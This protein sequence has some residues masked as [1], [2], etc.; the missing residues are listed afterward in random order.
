MS[1]H[2]ENHQKSLIDLETPAQI[3]QRIRSLPKIDLHRHLTGSIDA[4]LAIDIATKYDIF[5]P[6]YIYS[7][8][9][10]I[11]TKRPAA[12][13]H[14]DYFHRWEIL[15]KLFV[16]AESTFDILMNVIKKASED[17][18]VYMELRMGP[19]GFLGRNQFTF[20]DFLKTVARAVH[21]GQ[22]K[23]G[24][25]TRCI[26]GISRHETFSNIVNDV[27]EKMF[28]KI[29]SLI[30]EYYP[31]CFV[32]VDLNGIES[33]SENEL[34]INFFK[35]AKKKGLKI[36]A[37]AGELGSSSNIAKSIEIL[38]ADRIGH[39]LA[40]AKKPEIME[41]LSK[42]DIALEICPKSNEFLGVISNYKEL[43][44]TIFKENNV[45]YVISTDN[46]AICQTTISEELYRIYYSH[47]MSLQEIEAITKK[48]IKYSFATEEVK[49]KIFDKIENWGE[50]EFR[51]EEK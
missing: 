4:S 15:N 41:L 44:L 39:G 22:E 8:L 33:E 40:A 27:R 5:L 43:P 7:E 25:I 11:L 18:I 21:E 6:T 19:R 32:G 42:L 13:S 9:N 30:L 35:I 45:S 26:L 12:L 24:T 51:S 3:M 48:A 31:Y 1:T 16:S 36:T 50:H 2:L 29:I 23:Y 49:A 14:E 10:S 28:Y 46:P 17:N 38:N 47:K 34:Y 37:H 20:E